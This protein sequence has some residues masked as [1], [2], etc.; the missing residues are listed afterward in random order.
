MINAVESCSSE[1]TVC[2]LA[3]N[4]IDNVGSLLALA[5][6]MTMNFSRTF[7]DWKA[8]RIVRRPS[9]LLLQGYPRVVGE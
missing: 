2:L 6:I 9:G 7:A 5:D 8:R 1:G 4:R 3:L